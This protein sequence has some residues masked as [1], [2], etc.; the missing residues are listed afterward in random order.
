MSV[1]LN[2]QFERVCRNKSWILTSHDNEISRV[3][4]VSR[5]HNL[6]DSPTRPPSQYQLLLTSIYNK[7]VRY[8]HFHLGAIFW[9]ERTTVCCFVKSTGQRDRGTIWAVFQQW[10]REDPK[11]LDI[12]PMHHHWEIDKENHHQQLT[13]YHSLRRLGWTQ[14]WGGNTLK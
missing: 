6:V 7:S 3:V 2:H 14:S 8:Y 12:M 9:S 11:R 4:G 13:R 1:Q 10:P 5:A